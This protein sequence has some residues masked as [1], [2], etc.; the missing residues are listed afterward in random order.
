M[1]KISHVYKILIGKLNGREHFGDLNVEW[2][3]MLKMDLKKTGCDTV[4]CIH[5]PQDRGQWWASVNMV[6]NLQ[7]S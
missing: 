2:R 4:D 6:I 5:V 1:G 3:M 7:V